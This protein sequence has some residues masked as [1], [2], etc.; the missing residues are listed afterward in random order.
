VVGCKK[1][2]TLAFHP[3]GLRLMNLHGGK[4]TWP[5]RTRPGAETKGDL[6]SHTLSTPGWAAQEVGLHLENQTR[7][8]HLISYLEKDLPIFCHV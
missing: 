3:S 4:V 1:F 7:K 5:V 2:D 6:P 8:D